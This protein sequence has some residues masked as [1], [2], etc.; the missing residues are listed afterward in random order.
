MKTKS[1]QAEFKDGILGV[2]MTGQLKGLVC[3]ERYGKLII[4]YKKLKKNDK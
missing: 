1:N 2:K 4:Y 3:Y